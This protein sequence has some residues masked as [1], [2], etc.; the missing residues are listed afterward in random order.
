LATVPDKLEG[1]RSNRQPC[2]RCNF[3]WPS[4]RKKWMLLYDDSSRSGLSPYFFEILVPYWLRLTLR[5]ITGQR[6][7]F[8][9]PLAFPTRGTLHERNGEAA[10]RRR[11]V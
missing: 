5:G 2:S 7:R 11:P 3:S 1:A 9:S 8:A 4:T 6:N 10:S